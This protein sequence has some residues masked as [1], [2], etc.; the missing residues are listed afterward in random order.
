MKTEKVISFRVFSSYDDDKDYSDLDKFHIDAA[1]F[2]DGKTFYVFTDVLREMIHKGYNTKVREIKEMAEWISKLDEE[3]TLVGFNSNK[4][5]YQLLLKA[6]GIQFKTIDLMDSIGLAVSS[7]F[8]TSKKRYTLRECSRWNS[9]RQTLLPHFSWVF[10]S[11]ELF[12]EWYSERFRSVAKS[13]AA[14]CQMIAKLAHSIRR[15]KQVRVLD[16]VSGKGV[17]IPMDFYGQIIPR[18]FFGGA[19]DAPSLEGSE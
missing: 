6:Y 19:K 4:L 12:D 3:T 9:I 7:E 1:V 10:T 5:E 16:P 2:F 13:L 15:K 18:G 14:E 8:D 11:V 17:M